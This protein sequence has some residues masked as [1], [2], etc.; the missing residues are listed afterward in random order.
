MCMVLGVWD[1]SVKKPKILA[2]GNERLGEMGRGGMG[3]VGRRGEGRNK[4][5]NT[6]DMKMWVKG[7]CDLVHKDSVYRLSGLSDGG[8]RTLWR[9]CRVCVPAACECD[10][11]PYR[12]LDELDAWLQVQPKVDEV[13]FDAL[14]LVLLLLQD[15]HGVVEEL[16]QLLVG[17][18]DAQ[19]LERVHLST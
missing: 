2:F 16:L 5:R 18:V 10:V 3:V 4:K 19:L 7:Q 15:E 8:S 17:V 12:P 1:G 14:T 13:P 11:G 9:E 6:F